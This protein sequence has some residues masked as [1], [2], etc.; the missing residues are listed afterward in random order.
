[1]K[2]LSVLY[3]QA[4]PFIARAS[5]IEDADWCDWH[6]PQ[7]YTILLRGALHESAP[8]MRLAE[9][10]H[11]KAVLQSLMIQYSDLLDAD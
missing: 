5:T 4:L 10:L 7:A 11:G 2:S 3:L 9:P 8:S 1:M 6:F